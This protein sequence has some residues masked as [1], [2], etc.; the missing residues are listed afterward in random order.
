MTLLE[1]WVSLGGPTAVPPGV[2]FPVPNQQQRKSAMSRRY[3]FLLTGRTG[4]WQRAANA[5]T[6]RPG[7]GRNAR[8]AGVGSTERRTFLQRS[9]LWFANKMDRKALGAAWALAASLV[10][11]GV[12]G[13]IRI[14]MI[15]E[16]WMVRL[17]FIRHCWPTSPSCKKVRSNL[18]PSAPAR[19]PSFRSSLDKGGVIGAPAACPLVGTS[20][21]P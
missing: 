1:H 19:H 7:A 13:M 6:P 20:T 17:N 4:C 5:T 14:P 16:R 8:D 21:F 2:S 3:R 18:V 10:R 11:A 12:V 9:Y 15:R